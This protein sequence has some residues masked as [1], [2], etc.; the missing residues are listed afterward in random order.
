MDFGLVLIIMFANVLFMGNRT[1]LNEETK[2]MSSSSVSS[3]VVRVVDIVPRLIR[4]QRVDKTVVQEAKI[5]DGIRI[6]KE[7]VFKLVGGRPGRKR[8]LHKVA[9]IEERFG[10][11]VMECAFTPVS[12]A[13]AGEADL[14][15][16]LR[17]R[18]KK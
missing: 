5:P 13:E 3:K 17:L 11:A 6:Q 2:I 1:Y 4:G 10:G 18:V 12:E 7:A 8:G 14:V 16:T 15:P 9:R